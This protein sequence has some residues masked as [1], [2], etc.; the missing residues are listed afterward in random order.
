MVWWNEGGLKRKI[1]AECLV[2]SVVSPKLINAIYVSNLN[3]FNKVRESLNPFMS[4]PEIIC[5]PNFFFQPNYK[6][7]ISDFISVVRG[8][9]FFSNMQTLT[10]SVNC[11]G[12][13]GKGLASRAKYQFPDVYVYYQ[14]L[15]KKG[16]LSMGKP[17]LFKR[18]RS[19]EYQLADE[20]QE[21][22]T[23]NSAKWFLLFPTKRHW[24]DNS[25][26][27]RWTPKFG[28]AVKV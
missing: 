11:V 4:N 8:D 28:Q 1:M 6:T 17:F 9:M 10:V 5:E 12:I 13:M 19:I 14:D 18:E 16:T 27:K 2:P 7:E 20:P 15:C 3:V 25:D 23:L 21:L 26:I 24:R 22:G